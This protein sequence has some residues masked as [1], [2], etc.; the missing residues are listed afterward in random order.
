MHLGNVYVESN[1]D[2]SGGVRPWRRATRSRP[3]YAAKSFRIGS[4]LELLQCKP[5]LFREDLKKPAFCGQL[6]LKPSQGAAT[7]GLNSG[8]VFGNQSNHE[9][10]SFPRKYAKPKSSLELRSESCLLC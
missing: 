6:P 7:S 10:C 1:P 4:L 3:D 9:N 8:L 2:K 5:Q